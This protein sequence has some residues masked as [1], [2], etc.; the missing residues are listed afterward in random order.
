MQV[1]RGYPPEYAVQTLI[2]ANGLTT[3]AAMLMAILSGDSNLTREVRQ[4]QFSY[5]DCLPPLAQ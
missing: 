5:L 4:I 3:M 2:N 1:H